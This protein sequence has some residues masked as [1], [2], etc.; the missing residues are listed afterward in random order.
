M[1]QRVEEFNLSSPK[2]LSVIL[3]EKLGLDTKKSRKT[4]T[5]YSTN[6]QVLE[7]AAGRSSSNR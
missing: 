4:K 1:Q 7:K 2:Q 3:F 6:Q 5:G